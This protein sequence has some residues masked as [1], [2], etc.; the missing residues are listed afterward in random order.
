[1]A[2]A[3]PISNAGSASGA[4]LDSITGE[5]MN[6]A[7]GS[8]TVYDTGSKTG[9]RGATIAVL[10]EYSGKASGSVADSM[11]GAGAGSRMAT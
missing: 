3:R 8:G 4:E 9:S 11:T 10:K 2:I 7:A 1:V 5:W 6:G